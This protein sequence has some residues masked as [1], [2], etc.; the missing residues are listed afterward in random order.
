MG[1]RSSSRLPAR[2]ALRTRS[3]RAARALAMRPSFAS[4]SSVSLSY[5]ELY[6]QSA[7]Q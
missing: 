3:S 6:R 1:D 5:E 7:R 4:S 2:R